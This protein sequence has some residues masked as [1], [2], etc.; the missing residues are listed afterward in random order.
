MRWKGIL[1]L[2]VLIG[3]IAVLGFFLTDQWIER[4]I[5]SLGT[6]LVGAR[7]EIDDLDLSIF[8]LHTRWDS[9]Q[10]TDPKDTWK[11]IIATG[12][13]DFDIAFAPLLKKKFIIESFQINQIRTGIKRSYDGK[14]I[15]RKKVEAEPKKPS[16]LSKTIQKLE[17]EVEK[18]PAWNLEQYT[19]KVNVDSIIGLL[20]IK[21]P[22]K[23]DSVKKSL[24]AKYDFWEA[25]FQ[26]RDI[27]SE[28][29]EIE[30]LVKS[31]KVEEIKTLTA[32]QSTLSNIQQVKTRSDSIQKF[33]GSAKSNLTGDLKLAQ[34][35]VQ[36]VDNWIKDDYDRALLKARLPDINTQ[37]I[38][39]FIFGKRVIGYVNQVL[40]ITDQIRIYSAKYRSK[41]PKK[42]KPPRLKGQNIHFV[43]EN[44]LPALWIKHIL[45][46]GQ[47]P[48]KLN[49]S[50]RIDHIVSNQKLIHE[51]TLLEFYGKRKDGASFGLDG[52]LDYRQEEANE[53]FQLH[54]IRIPLSDV[55]LSDS[56][57][58]PYKVT[59][60]FASIQASLDLGENTF[61]SDIRFVADQLV[62]AVQDQ[63]VSV[64]ELEKI[65]QSV[66]K[67][68]SKLDFHAKMKNQGDR[69]TFSLNSNLDD[70][71]VNR[72]RSIL[73]AEMES[74]KHK[75]KSE[76]DRHVSKLE[77]EHKTL[78][79][80]KQDYFI[81][82]M[83]TYE[84]M[85]VEKLQMVE[86]KKKE[87]EEKIESEKNKQ[88][89]KLEEEAKKRLQNIL[90]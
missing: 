11:N 69:L 6:S 46:S 16:F 25:T 19:K 67:N 20:D 15:K 61:R 9:L 50:G 74:A 52:T 48:Q 45:I 59:K 63:D 41:E 14:V 28:L 37:N 27:E 13:C 5:E 58:L 49:L 31:I 79:R 18:A 29:K 73:S 83:K 64:N 38:G 71:L 57:F 55:K 66:V 32:L 90:K 81:K 40:S 70:L 72:I 76:V 39:K 68:T 24:E 34:N 56:P 65:I 30:G 51:P 22:A 77:K 4:R 21:S 10:I 12:Q 89:N 62:F 44:V 3:L 35:T 23:I 80:N 36:L 84:Q 8:T 1:F 85:L 7:V 60:G 87:I 2:L 26:E 88:S 82:E 33:F 75:L 78:V 53:T 86:N 43:K 47:T 17:H 42:E 54:M